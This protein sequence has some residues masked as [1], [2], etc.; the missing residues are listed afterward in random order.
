[1]PLLTSSNLAKESN[2]GGQGELFGVIGNFIIAVIFI[3][4]MVFNALFRK[5]ERNFYWWMCLFIVFPLS[6]LRGSYTYQIEL[7]N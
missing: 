4:I 1:M 3:V 5:M 2:V 6:V 7:L